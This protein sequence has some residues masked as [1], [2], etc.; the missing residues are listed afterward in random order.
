MN[1]RPPSLPLF[2]YPALFRFSFNARRSTMSWIG[3]GNVAGVLLHRE[4]MLPRGESLL[5]RP[6]VL[7]AELPPLYAPVLAVARGDLLS[8][9]TGRGRIGIGEHEN[10]D[11]AS[12]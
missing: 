10:L 8:L 2:P 1:R 5:L 11:D 3:V 4:A 12:Q 9:A 6:G 7:G